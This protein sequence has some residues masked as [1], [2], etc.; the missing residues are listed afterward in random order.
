MPILHRDYETR[1]TIN[2]KKSGA[3]RYASHPS[4]DVWC[5]AYAVDDGPVQLW[6]AGDPV[7][8]A[9]LEAASSDDWLVAAHNDAFERRIEQH[10]M[11]PRY[12]WPLVLVERHRCTMAQALAVALPAAGKRGG[13]AAAQSSKV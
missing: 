5:C 12:G 2:L 8:P 4:T 9:W 1:G 13:G 10:I 6:L 11:G 7:P 3:W